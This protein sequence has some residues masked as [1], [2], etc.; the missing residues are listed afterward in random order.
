MSTSTITAAAA[1]TPAARR[2]IAIVG[3]GISGL[4]AAYLLNRRHDITLFE[5]DSRIGGHTHTV[6]VEVASGRYAIDTG[7]IVCNDWT[8]PNFYRLLDQIGVQKKPSSM[9]FSAHGGPEGLEWAGGGIDQLFAQRRNL[10]SPRYL[11]MLLEIV[12]FNRE[13]SALLESAEGELTLGE[14]LQRHRYSSLFR[15]YYVL[16]MGAAIWSASVDDMLKFPARF[17]VTFFRNHGLLSVA[18]RPQ[19]RVIEGGSRGYLA[20]LTRSF[21]D[22]IRL[23]SPV[24]S[25]RRH[26]DGVELVVRGQSPEQFDD[27]VFACHGDQALAILGADAT[28]LEREVLGAIPWQEND[29]VLHTDTTLLP[30]L[31][32]TWS[33]WNYRLPQRPGDRVQLTYNMNILQSINA[34]ETFCVTLNATQKIDPAKILGRYTYHHPGYTLD[35]MKARAR[36]DEISRDRTFFCGAYWHNGF[37]EDGVNSALAVAARFGESL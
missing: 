26:A 23:S 37:H 35:G 20:P 14:Y 27:V 11:R 7:F 12:R 16:A 6:D 2:R 3:S 1:G 24:E 30:S 29:V 8:Y 19:W 9:G 32:K 17:F 21:A 31:R 18:N 15:D 33:S 25:V 10:F 36:R 34:P 13:A 5:A 22:R 4:T 28:P